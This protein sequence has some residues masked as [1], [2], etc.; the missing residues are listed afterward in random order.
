MRQVTKTIS[1]RNKVRSCLQYCQVF[2][3]RETISVFVATISNTVPWADEMNRRISSPF[4]CWAKEGRNCYL[5]AL[6]GLTGK[7]SFSS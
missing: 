1:V 4:S 7:V 5:S 2:N 6:D 3:S